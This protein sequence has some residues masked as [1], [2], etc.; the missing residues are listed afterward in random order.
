VPERTD[1]GASPSP[2]PPDGLGTSSPAW[3]VE[4]LSG[5]GSAADASGDNVGVASQRHLSDN[6]EVASKAAEDEDAMDV[7]EGSADGE[8]ALEPEDFAELDAGAKV[9][10]GPDAE[11]FDG[12][13][14]V[15]RK[16][17]GL[18]GGHG[19]GT[20][21]LDLE[22]SSQE[23]P[24]R[25]GVGAGVE[26]DDGAGS[27]EKN[28]SQPG[29]ASSAHAEGSHTPEAREQAASRASPPVATPPSGHR[30]VTK[31]SCAADVANNVYLKTHAARLNALSG[32]EKE[33]E[34]NVIRIL[35]R[36][37]TTW[38]VMDIDMRRNEEGLS[39]RD[40]LIALHRERWTSTKK[41][42]IMQKHLDPLRDAW[43]PPNSERS[44]LQAVDK[45]DF[46]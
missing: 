42:R 2:T 7:S 37:F 23:L 35:S 41:C 39:F 21:L 29:A 45:E 13:E 28:A 10:Q 22:A 31:K 26:S 3:N 18:A 30:R 1:H 6:V 11:G 15:A 34:N 5:G 36:S 19:A 9:K 25:R 8:A 17:H 40:G 38:T 24:E 20:R 14:P 12:T 32:L 4:N 27:S 33:I 46:R 43:C 44:G 16:F